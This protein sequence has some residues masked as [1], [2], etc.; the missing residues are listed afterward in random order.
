MALLYEAFLEVVPDDF[1]VWYNLGNH[2]GRLDRKVEAIGAY[3]MALRIKP[4]FA[5]AH[6]NRGR[7]RYD[8]GTST[9]PLLTSSRR[10]ATT[11]MLKNFRTRS[12]AG[13]SPYTVSSRWS[14]SSPKRCFFPRISAKI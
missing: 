12:P 1:N 11:A 6:Y 3:D 13:L 4:E 8:L 5:R 9:R 14:T 10:P 7:V 2:L